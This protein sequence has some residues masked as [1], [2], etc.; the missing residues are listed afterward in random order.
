MTSLTGQDI[1]E[2]GEALGPDYCGTTPKKGSKMVENRHLAKSISDQSFGAPVATLCS[3]WNLQHTYRTLPKK[4]HVDV[5]GT[6]AVPN[7][8]TVIFNSKLAIHLG[9][10]EMIDPDFLCRKK[11]PANAS[12]LAMAYAG[13]QFGH[14]NMLGDGRACLLG[15]QMAPNGNLYDVH[16]KGSGPTEFSR[17]G[18]GLATL[19]PMLREYIISEAMAAL[20][21]ET[22]RSLAVISTGERV[23]RGEHLPGAVL[24]RIAKSHIRV[25]TFI[26]AATLRDK[27]SLRALADY[28]IARHFPE[29][30]AGDYLGLLQQV[31]QR[32]AKLLSDWMTV[33]FV[34]GVMNTD[35]MSICGESI[36]FGPCAFM[37]HYDEN[38]VFSSIDEHGR[39]AYGNQPRIAHWNLTRFAEALL[40][41]LD[42][43]EDRAEE[44]A[45]HE[46]STFPA[47]YDTFSLDR[48]RTKLGISKNFDQPREVVA[49]L[50]A[51]MKDESLD[52]TNT[53]RALCDP[54]FSQR[55]KQNW[56]PAML[57][58]L[59]QWR[60][61]V[62]P[63][64][65]TKAA[66]PC[67]IPRNHLVEEAL[68]SAIQGDQKLFLEMLVLLK[69]PFDLKEN[70]ARY[71][72]PAL[73]HEKVEATFCGT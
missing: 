56:P 12:P 7:A 46:L 37:D 55:I 63:D 3:G 21:I 15:E 53:F 59:N 47:L 31:I 54:E 4:F 68:K 28:T 65:T 11:I 39:Y 62:R 14:L 49:S 52:F 40:P 48:W 50:F 38:T 60:D 22:T 24:C 25:G 5:L 6:F 32:Q 9:L 51:V 36:D 72:M 70:D 45:M 43:N 16:L 66:N 41:I 19:G 1:Q 64:S 20:G 57:Q 8:T 67:Y 10:E 29:L 17:R 35:N 2:V 13:H 33:G 18:D 30:T 44:L 73:P 42:N 34:H 23:W 26:Y 71:H 61:I 58:W 27:A 69:T